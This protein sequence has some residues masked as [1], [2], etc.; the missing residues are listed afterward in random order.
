MKQIRQKTAR[1]SEIHELIT[2]RSWRWYM[3]HGTPGG[4]TWGGQGRM[5][6][7][8]VQQNLGHVLLLGSAGGALWGS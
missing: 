8:L 6:T 3:V 2:H 4:A 1:E 7:E 5:Q